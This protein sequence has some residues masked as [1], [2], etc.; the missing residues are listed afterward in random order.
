MESV[1]KNSASSMDGNHLAHPLP[2][3]SP[4]HLP[5]TPSPS[6]PPPTPPSKPLELNIIEA[7]RQILNLSDYL[8]AHPQESHH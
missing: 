8:S 4:A 2:A 5:N 6:A 3:T 7:P 1:R